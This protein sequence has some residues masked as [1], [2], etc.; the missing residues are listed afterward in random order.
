M[1]ICV[2]RKR[3]T[4]QFLSNLRKGRNKFHKILEQKLRQT[5]RTLKE[6]LLEFLE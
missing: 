5:D 6:S 3:K 4:V 2:G 1:K